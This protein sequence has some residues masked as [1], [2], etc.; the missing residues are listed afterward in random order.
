MKKKWLITTVI[1][2]PVLLIAG[3][4]ATRNDWTAYALRRMVSSQS[5]GQITLDF[6]KVEVGVFSKTL[7]IF[8]PELTFRKFYFNKAQGTTLNRA[9]FQKLTLNNISLGDFLWHKRFLCN[10]LTIEKPAFILK[11]S[12]SS[13]KTKASSFDPA[14]LINVL[15]NHEITHLKFQFLIHH[16][17]INFGNIRI[18]EKNKKG[19]YGSALYNMSIEDLGTI[20]TTG[21]TLRPLSFKKFTLS[22]RAFHRFSDA[23]GMDIKLDSAFYTSQNSSLFLNGLQ[24]TSS[25]NKK[26]KAPATK[27]YLRWAKISGLKTEKLKKTG[28]KVLQLNNIRIVGGSYTY[29]FRSKKKKKKSVSKVL[30][31]L[32]STYNIFSLD[33]LSISHIHLF[34]IGKNQDTLLHIRRLNLEMNKIWTTKMILTNPIKN[35]HYQKLLASYQ[36]MSYGDDKKPLYLRSG[37]GRYISG[38]KQLTIHNITVKTRCKA[39]TAQSVTFSA[40]KFS[41]DSL[42]EDEFRKGETQRLN[43]S[44]VSPHI[45]WK[46]DSACSKKSVILPAIFNT[47][48]IE[49]INFS[50]GSFNYNSNQNSSLAVSGIDFF[51]NGLYGTRLSGINASILYD[52]LYFKSKKCRLNATNTGQRLETGKILWRNH[53]LKISALR[54]VQSRP[55]KQDT[56][57]IQ[58][59]TLT[60]PKLNP[61]VFDQT[62]VARGAYLYKAAFSLSHQDS[63]HLRT[64]TLAVKHWNHFVKLPFKTNITYVRV[65]KSRFNMISRRPG[66][67]FSIRSRVDLK[68]YGLKIG[69]DTT[70]LISQP[71]RW[72]ATLHET[73]I[74]Q[75]NLTARLGKTSL[76]SLLGTLQ[77]QNLVLR[78]SKDK[79]LQFRIHIPDISLQSMNYLTLLHSDS[80][81]FGKAIL[82]RGGGNIRLINFKKDSTNKRINRWSFVY[83]SIMLNN[84]GLKMSIGNKENLKV[85]HINNL[86]LL[87]HP[88]LLHPNILSK[89]PVNLMKEWDFTIRKVAYEDSLRRFHIVADRVAAQSGRSRINIK[90]I[91]GTNFSSSLLQPKTRNIYTYFLLYNMSLDGIHISNGKDKALR[92]KSWYIPGMWVNIINNDTIKKRKPVSFLSSNF[93]S[94]YTHLLG[95]I[96][97][98]SSIFKNVNFSYQYDKM[99]KLVNIKGIHIST[100]NIQLGEG[101]L[102]NNSDA[103]FGS[104]F[105]NLND[106][107]IISGDSLYSFRTKDIRI[108]LADRK[109]NLDSITIVPRYGRKDFF[110]RVGYQTDR[111]TLYGKSAVLDNFNPEDLLNNHFIHFGNLRLNNLSLRFERD[112]HYPRRENIVKPMPIDMLAMV[113]YKFRIDSVHLNNS[114]ISY[115]EYEVISKNPG[116]FFIDNFNVLA[117]NVTNNLTKRDSNLVLKFHGYGKLM[118]QSKLDFTLVMPY[119]APHRQWWFSAEAGQIDLTQFNLLTENVLGITVHSGIGSLDVPMITGND[120]AARG[121]VNF[122]YKKLKL[123]LY[124]RKKSQKSKKFYSPFANFMM[125]SIIIKS[126]NPPFL[127]HTKKGIVYFERVPYKSF[128]G[129]LWKSNLSG[130]L[131]TLGFNNKQQREGKRE[132]KKQTKIEKKNKPNPKKKE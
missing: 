82:Q 103:L 59:V 112:M 49:K 70:Q 111:I 11:H 26:I 61:L 93:F 84:T 8:K 94:D 31:S 72:Q 23:D 76:N 38:K 110:A 35:L 100:N 106:R 66:N 4:Y 92:I 127:G 85:I 99:S 130:I 3:I 45:F 62:L 104:M 64:D 79:N 91:T 17:Q 83:D 116:I 22:V 90:R 107:A 80:L 37:E 28:E 10:N 5:A 123:R 114:M 53:L 105:V 63:T 55:E 67:N 41:I 60:K 42:S 131:S 15:Q 32:L 102:G 78:Q 7:T 129:Y 54:F 87:Y 50:G 36:A 43:V 51:A 9:K 73:S 109:I 58:S 12:H 20:R 18:G 56:L 113:P 115:F 30:N 19:F 81:V 44:M 16:S 132:E 14:S 101:A 118:K 77:V 24:V 74:K 89:A 57:S 1:L 34:E 13:V 126:N 128:I 6:S 39:D 46:T 71:K 52:S 95:S 117:E 97:V 119:F 25:D 2:L 120:T 86:N 29:R 68:L 69:Y 33:S 98:D 27:L 96:H 75:N 47:L 125:N 21:D 88:E 124:N 65:K 48:K 122:L 108:N 121:N 40:R